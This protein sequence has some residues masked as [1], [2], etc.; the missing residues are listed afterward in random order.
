[1]SYTI[2]YP[3]GAATVEALAATGTLAVTISNQVTILDGVTTP[4]SGNRTVNL[5]IS[6]EVIKGAVIVAKIKTAGTQTCTWGTGF[7]AP[8]M[9]GVAGKTIVVQFMYDGTAF[10]QTGA[11]IQLD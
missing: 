1:M 8:T 7:T 6:D 10:I 9:T 4:S 11:E 5:T 2:K 3:Y